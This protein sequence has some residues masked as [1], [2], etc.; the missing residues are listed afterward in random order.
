MFGIAVSGVDRKTAGG[1]GQGVFH[2][3]GWKPDTIPINPGTSFLEDFSGAL[4]FHFQAYIFQDMENAIIQ[5]L[6]LIV[7]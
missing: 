3:I 4:V 5:L 2:Q 1:F 7:R 6:Q